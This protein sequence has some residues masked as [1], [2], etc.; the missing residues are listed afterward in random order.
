MDYSSFTV[1]QLKA[2]LKSLG[3]KVSGTKAELIKRIEEEGRKQSTL[4]FIKKSDSKV[5]KKRKLEEDIEVPNQVDEEETEDAPGKSLQCS[6]RYHKARFLSSPEPEAKE[7]APKLS[8]LDI[9]CMSDTLTE[10]GWKSILQP[11]F[12]KAYYKRIEDYVAKQRQ[13]GAVFPPHHEVY[14]AFN[15]TPFDDVRVVI[16][17]QDPYFNDGQAEGLCFSVKKGVKIPPS[18]N[19]IYKVQRFLFFFDLT[20]GARKPNTRI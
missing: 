5:T 15:L 20:L 7:P 11:V 18:L 19:R 4:S 14:N 12:E 6:L 9:S 10:P 8:K 13:I 2:E 3:L 1:P 16:L 17:G